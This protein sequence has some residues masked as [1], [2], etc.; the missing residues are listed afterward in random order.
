MDLAMAWHTLELKSSRNWSSST[1][2]ETLAGVFPFDS[3][4][5]AFN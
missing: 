3:T 1:A 4:Q 5:M 2:E